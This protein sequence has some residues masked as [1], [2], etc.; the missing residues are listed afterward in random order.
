MHS[1]VFTYKEVLIIREM[2]DLNSDK[3]RKENLVETIEE[4]KLPDAERGSFVVSSHFTFSLDQG[5][6]ERQI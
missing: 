5:T 1:L 2:S 6:K 3:I 4:P